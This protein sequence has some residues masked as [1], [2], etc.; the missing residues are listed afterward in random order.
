MRGKAN[1]SVMRLPKCDA[2]Y[3][4]VVPEI[5]GILL[6]FT[7]QRLFHIPFG[8]DSHTNEAVSRAAAPD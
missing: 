5:V 6:I 1:L 8:S 2:D 4:L 3:A 7:W